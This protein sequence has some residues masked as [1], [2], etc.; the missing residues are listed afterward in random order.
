MAVRLALADEFSEA[1]KDGDGQLT[2]T[3]LVDYVKARVPRLVEKLKED[4]IP[5]I[6]PGDTQ[7][8]SVFMPRLE[9]SLPWVKN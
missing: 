4:E 5:G 7:T 3:E 2:T 9:R 6:K 1:D 8:P